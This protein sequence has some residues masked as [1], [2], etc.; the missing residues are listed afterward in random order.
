MKIL[1]LSLLSLFVLSSPVAAQDKLVVQALERIEKCE[2][3]AQTMKAGDAG[4]ASRCI[5]DLDWAAKRLNAAYDKTAEPYLAAVKRYEAVRKK[6]NDLAASGS[7][8]AP[9][10]GFDADKLAQLD[11]EV[12]DGLHNFKLLGLEHM[13][14]A[15]RVGML[16][17]ELEKLQQR[18]AVFP[19]DDAR[20]KVVASHL[21]DF[22]QAFRTLHARY[23]KDLVSAGAH[24]ARLTELD[25]K[26]DSKQTPASLE[27]PFDLDQLRSWAAQVRRWQEK[28]IPQDLAWLQSMVGTGGVDKQHVSRLQHWIGGD[29]VRRLDEARRTVAQRVGS[30][31]DEALRAAEWVQATDPT[32]SSHVANRILGE[33]AF[34]GQMQRLQAGLQA[35]D[36]A[37]VH[38][39]VLGV[40]T[41]AG[42]DR[43]A[44]RQKVD[45]AIE[46]L[47]KVAVAALDQVRM[48]AAAS[49]DESLLAIA[50]EALKLEKYGVGAVE[51]IV[52]NA[53]LQHR[54]MQ[55]GSISR[56]AASSTVTLY[57]YVWD[58][59]QVCTAEK[60]GEEY[61]L[62]FNTLKK[63]SS[64]D[65]TTPLGSWILSKRFKSTRIL[66]KNL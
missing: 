46:H 23:E 27:A 2:K 16:R 64:G 31:V 61:W 21:A 65:S 1:E 62:Y 24:A 5:A 54:Q 41:G 45:A 58:E 63:Y 52:I 59:F 44:Q 60:E 39:D 13:G 15:S 10:A 49:T 42:S 20:V 12:G 57:S 35:I 18:L 40:D 26:Y 37:A 19:A 30:D 43:A 53:A 48:P 9:A 11:K 56:G 6:I 3:A 32:D 50:R 7:A 47:R 14:D 17:R 8:P 22:E 36:I 55:S 25:A 29:W 66:P 4:A 51:R 28:E 38:D 33:G 34:D